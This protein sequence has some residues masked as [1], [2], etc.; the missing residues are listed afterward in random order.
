MDPGVAIFTVRVPLTIK[1]IKLVLMSARL[2]VL[3]MAKSPSTITTTFLLAGIFCG[4]LIRRLPVF[5]YQ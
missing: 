3:L 4:E 1:R 5:L 2:I